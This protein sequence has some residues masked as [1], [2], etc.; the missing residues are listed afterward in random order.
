MAALKS[1][2]L[3]LLHLNFTVYWGPAVQYLQ[4]PSTASPQHALQPVSGSLLHLLPPHAGNRPSPRRA[5]CK[6]S[7]LHQLRFG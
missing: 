3:A 2:L 5:T 7:C 4:A 1:R 6:G